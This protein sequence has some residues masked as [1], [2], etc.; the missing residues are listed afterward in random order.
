MIEQP[1]PGAPA[2]EP[3]GPVAEPV[4]TPVQPVGQGGEAAPAPAEPRRGRLE[5]V[6]RF[7][8]TPVGVTG[9]VLLVGALLGGAIVGVGKVQ[10]AQREQNQR[11]PAAATPTTGGAT[12]GNGEAKAAREKEIAD[13]V[14]KALKD[15]DQA[16]AEKAKAKAEAD[17]KAKADA[18][19]A[20]A[21]L[22]DK[23]LQRVANEAH[24]KR[25]AE[26]D[27][28]FRQK[29]TFAW[30]IKAGF[31]FKGLSAKQDARQVEEET[32]TV[33][34][35][36]RILASGVQ[37]VVTNLDAPWPNALTTS[38]PSVEG[39]ARVCVRPDPGNPSR[40]C[41]DVKGFTGEATLYADAQNWAQLAPKK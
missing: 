30:L 19:T 20:P 3:H 7:A 41:T 38:D 27:P 24:T 17:A 15:R 2:P 6:G 12:A 39:K 32:L 4:A 23:E 21:K 10:E 26:L 35:N 8:R 16:D 18:T 36:T 25:L 14:E 37:V 13:A 34:G 40:L 22:D 33:D 9:S 5:R 31:S 1:R 11:P 29:G 28:E